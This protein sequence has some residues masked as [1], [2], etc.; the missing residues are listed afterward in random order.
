[1]EAVMPGKSMGARSYA[2]IAIDPAITIVPEVFGRSSFGGPAA[3]FHEYC[4][5]G[6]P[7]S[8]RQSSRI[9][10]RP[11]ADAYVCYGKLGGGRA[12]A[13]R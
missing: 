10:G 1:M 8:A 7:T 2:T 3:L 13:R 12:G 5:R 6:R 9:Y 11:Q 4:H